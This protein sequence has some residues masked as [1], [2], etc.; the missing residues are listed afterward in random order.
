[1]PGKF[2]Y[3]EPEGQVG[4]DLD[5]IALASVSAEWQVNVNGVPIVD[6]P[7]SATGKETSTIRLGVGENYTIVA[8]DVVT[9][10]H[11]VEDSGIA[12]FTDQPVVNNG[13]AAPA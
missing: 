10:T 7:L 4:V 8:G 11:L 3:V 9:V 6:P 12:A 5:G 1:M 2:L 13:P